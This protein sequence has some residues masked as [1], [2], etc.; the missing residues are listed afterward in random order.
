[1]SS[2]EI[3]LEVARL[4]KATIDYRKRTEWATLASLFAGAVSGVATWFIAEPID[5]DEIH[6]GVAMAVGL[7]VLL[8]G[9]L[10]FRVLVPKP[11]PAQCS[12]CGYIWEFPNEGGHDWLEWTNCPGCGLK[13]RASDREAP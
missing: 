13:M 10:L 7:G 4:R 12:Q 1:M 11:R 5:R 9:G 3:D 8:A 2:Q 6:A